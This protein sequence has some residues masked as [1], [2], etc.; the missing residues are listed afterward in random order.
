MTKLGFLVA[1]SIQVVSPHWLQLSQVLDACACLWVSVGVCGWLWVSVDISGSLTQ[2]L[3]VCAGH[4]GHLSV[5][6]SQVLDV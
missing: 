6:L 5:Q 3:N 2:M 4:V 1:A